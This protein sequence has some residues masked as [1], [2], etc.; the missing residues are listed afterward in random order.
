MISVAR[1]SM[2]SKPGVEVAR[3]YAQEEINT[4]LLGT[5]LS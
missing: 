3:S 2:I 1:L 4:G 5:T